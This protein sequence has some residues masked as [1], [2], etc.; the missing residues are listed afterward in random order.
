[1]AAI[2]ALVAINTLLFLGLSMAK[3][4]PWPDPLHPRALRTRASNVVDSADETGPRAAAPMS[5]RQVILMSLVIALHR[6]SRRKH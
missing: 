3:V 4:A 1:M 6:L 5:L 2:L